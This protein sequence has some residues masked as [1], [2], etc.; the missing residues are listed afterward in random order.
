MFTRGNDES[1]TAIPL[2]L[3]DANAFIEQHHRTHKPVKFHLFSIGAM[4]RGELV[5]VCIVFR[6]AA[7]KLDDGFTAEVSRLATDGTQNTCS[8]LLSR[9]RKAAFAMGFTTIQ[10]YTRP[11]EGGASL[12]ASGWEF[13]GERGGVSWNMS[14]R[15]RKDKHPVGKKHFWI[16]E[17]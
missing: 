7:R 12:R 10:T 11:E 15:S 9:A 1:L 16:C 3:R 4:A 14:G 2:R 13:V 5:G 6:P 17:K 8:F